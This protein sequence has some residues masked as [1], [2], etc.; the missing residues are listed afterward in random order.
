MK[1][2]LFEYISGG[3][4]IKEAIPRSLAREGDLMLRALLD[5]LSEIDKTQLTTM[6][7]A[8]L[9]PPPLKAGKADRDLVRVGLTD[10]FEELWKAA[11]RRVDA[12]W[13]IA[14]ETGGVLE[15]LCR[16][17]R[18]CGK[19]LLNSPAEAVALTAAKFETLSHLNRCGIDVV[20]TL[21]LADFRD[22]F[23]GPWVVKPNDGAGC[24][25]TRM[26]RNQRQL[27]RLQATPQA[28]DLIIQPFLEGDAMSLSGLFKQGNAL[29]LS[30]N[31]Q[32]I[33]IKYDYFSLS[34]CTVNIMPVG[35]EGCSNLA[36]AIARAI[37]ALFGYAGVDLI[38]VGG[39]P[40][41]LE[42]NPR[43]TTSYAGLSKAL[44]RNVAAMV[45]DLLPPS[46]RLPGSIRNA[47]F[48][49]DIKVGATDGA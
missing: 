18:E 22:Q 20:P 24:E 21:R 17:V 36:R 43:L 3:G 14:P 38:L 6:C 29:L 42:I 49:I 39:R 8:R 13:P 25:G 26:V 46:S 48:E 11:I 27:S 33:D 1:I 32:H 12:V 4:L 37:P 2:L 5:D 9:E 47:G 16:E 40:M 31:R 15:K 34:G 30:C 41:V 19:I 23:S 28:K 10:G 45:V 35:D 7:D 44:N